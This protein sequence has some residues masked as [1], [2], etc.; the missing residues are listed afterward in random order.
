MVVIS[1]G[2]AAALLSVP[3]SA[4]SS[5]YRVDAY[6]GDDV[7]LTLCNPQVRVEVRGDGDTDLDFTITNGSGTVL[8]SDV[9][10]TDWTVTNIDNGDS[11]CRKY[12]LHVE[13]YGEVYNEYSVEMTNIA[14]G[15]SVD[16][17]NR[18]VAVHNHT[19]ETIYYIYWSNTGDNSWRED[20]LGSDVL[21]DGQEWS[22]QV[23]DGSG[24]CRFDFK[25]R[26]A[27]SREIVRNNVNVCEV[28][29]VDF[30]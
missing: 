26:T 30:D 15:S 27:S 13:N 11:E 7:A 6:G 22:V 20:R 24:A 3:A 10:E 16:G 23:D 1:C 17:N 9:D 21:L 18:D 2:A 5:T 12:N 19:G 4:Q 28:S 8:H 25:I 29:S 14:S